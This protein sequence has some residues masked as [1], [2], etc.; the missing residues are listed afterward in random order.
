MAPYKSMVVSTGGGAVQDPMNWSYMHNGIVAWLQGDTG[1]LARRVVAEGVEKRPLLYGEGVTGETRGRAAGQGQRLVCLGQF[2][3]VCTRQKCLHMP[4][5]VCRLCCVCVML[6]ASSVD[7]HRS[8][9][10]AKLL[11]CWKPAPPHLPPTH[12]TTHPPALLYAPPPPSPAAAPLQ[13]PMRTRWPMP[14]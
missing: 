13:R 11:A 5:W 8:G 3:A 14:S 2:V 10:R 7:W 1:L 12:T 9:W 6:C 4:V